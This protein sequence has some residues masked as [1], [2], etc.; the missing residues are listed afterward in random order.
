MHHGTLLSNQ[1]GSWKV[2]S[3]SGVRA[4]AAGSSAHL[5]SIGARFAEASRRREMLEMYIWANQFT[6]RVWFQLLAPNYKK[7]HPSTGLNLPQIQN[8]P[9]PTTTTTGPSDT[10]KKPKSP[11]QIGRF[12]TDK[13]VSTSTVLH[14]STQR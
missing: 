3:G 6:Y 5:H 11:Q 10:G 13:S 1:G 14:C 7:H 9:R 12:G 8:W 4:G 2:N